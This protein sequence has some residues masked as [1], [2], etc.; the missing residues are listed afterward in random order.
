MGCNLTIVTVGITGRKTIGKRTE[1]REAFYLQRNSHLSTWRQ[2]SQNKNRNCCNVGWE[3]ARSPHRG[4]SPGRLAP[5]GTCTTFQSQQTGTCQQPRKHFRHKFFQAAKPERGWWSCFCLW[6][7]GTP[8]GIRGRKGENMVIRSEN[9]TCG[10]YD[11][12]P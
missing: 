7:Q 8:P 5:R 9:V 3:W 10:H 1:P 11:I 4:R 12:A 6:L 2:S